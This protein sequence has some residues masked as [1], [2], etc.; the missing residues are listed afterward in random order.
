M[1]VLLTGA[2]GYV[3]KRLLPELLNNG[4]EVVCCIRNKDRLGLD[5]ITLSKITI[6]E[7]DFL[8]KPILENLPKKFDVAFY[9]IHSMTSSTDTF[10]E[11]E[12]K[13]ALN[14]K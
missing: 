9:L 2:N 13:A 12:T 8:E 1:R 5:R 10:D 7:I 6:W 4:H 14:F 11:L 3:G